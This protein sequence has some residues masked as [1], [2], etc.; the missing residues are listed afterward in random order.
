MC[1]NAGHV[2]RSSSI[3]RSWEPHNEISEPSSYCPPS[4][5][6]QVLRS[7]DSRRQYDQQLSLQQTE[8]NTPISE[9]VD[10]TDM[11]SFLE[12]GVYWYSHPCRCGSAFEVPDSELDEGANSIVIGCG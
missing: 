4:A 1:L 6:M 9:E 2:R 10:L 3:R 8:A 12:D 7:P 11:D 5:T